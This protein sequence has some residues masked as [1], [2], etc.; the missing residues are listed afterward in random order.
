MKLLTLD[1]FDAIFLVRLDRRALGRAALL[2]WLVNDELLWLDTLTVFRN[3]GRCGEI[4]VG[5][6]TEFDRELVF[7]FD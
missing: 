5:G 6:V 7:V 1:V 3:D 2:F 4:D